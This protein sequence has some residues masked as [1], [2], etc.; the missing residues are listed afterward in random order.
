MMI[1]YEQPVC[2]TQSDLYS[3]IQEGSKKVDW[4]HARLSSGYFLTR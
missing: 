1:D 3:L 4:E 2:Q